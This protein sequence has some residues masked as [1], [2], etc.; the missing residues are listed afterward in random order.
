MNE[1]YT[2][3]RGIDLRYYL[4]M[5]SRRRWVIILPFLLAMLVGVILTIKLPKLY[6]ASILILIQRQRVPEKMV[7]SVVTSDIEYRIST[8]SQQILSRN[9]LEKVIEQ[10]KLFSSP[11][12]K[13]LFMED[14]ITDLRKRINVEVSRSR[15]DR[16]ADA[17]TI[18]YQDRDPQLTMRVANGLAT[19][20]IDE[21]LKVRETQAVGTS[22]FL[23]AELESTRVR[24]EQVEKDLQDYRLKTMGELPEQFESNLRILDRLNAQLLEKEQSLRSA[25][26]SLTALENET[27]ARQSVMEAAAAPAGA[28]EGEDAQTLDQLKDRLASLL[29][30]YTDQHPDVVRLKA[31]IEKLEADP[32]A[33]ATPARG[34]AGASP[35][36]V[37]RAESMR[38][39][40]LLEGTIRNLE[41]DIGRINQEVREYQRRVD[42]TPKREQEM[43]ALKR[44]YENIKASYNSLLDRKLQ[45]Q[46]SVNMEKK[47]KG[48]Q[49]QVI[50]MARVPERPV[51][52]DMKKL[53]LIVLLAGLGL[54]GGAVFALELMDSSMRRPS[55]FEDH[56]G[57]PVLAAVTWIDSRADRARRNLNRALTAV[58]VLTALT[59]T[60]VMAWMAVNGVEPAMEL[61]RQYTRV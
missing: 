15:R 50:D 45:A 48:E 6:E 58:S 51:S 18:S 28:K 52:P 46:I 42:A 40:V 10:F 60:G 21:N 34:A 38:Q 12:S 54:G 49:F 4:A 43:L 7:E 19:F 23:E 24:L 39:K 61:L 37:V 29:A 14:K 9:N 47:Q 31:R 3:D 36:K 16:D 1:N 5:I 32:A 8:I 55:D 17:F 22:D 11:E 33:H 56:L 20:F 30:S 59:L 44:D 25:R 27:V 13:K 26:T 2:P 57:L 41:I 35:S 53:F